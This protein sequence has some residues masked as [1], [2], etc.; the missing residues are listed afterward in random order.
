MPVSATYS[1][2]LRAARRW[3]RTPEAARDLVQTALVEAVARGFSDWE[4]VGRRGWLH[5][6][7]RRQA[8]FQ[9]RGEARQRRRERL[10]QLDREPTGAVAWA[11]A[12][13]FLSTLA[14]SLRAVA[15]LTQAGLG[16]AEVRS[17]LRLT[18][19]AFRQRL[20]ALRRALATTAEPTIPTGPAEGPGLG[21]RRQGVLATLRRQSSGLLAG[22][23]V[24][25]IRTAIR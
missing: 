19:V 14:P 9:A 20:T 7:I 23:S 10:W 4:A 22:P 5:G 25:T 17:V 24:L 1:E 18:A 12:P 13:R 3:T 11:W 16:A 21:P 15:L 8:A 2:L 6:V